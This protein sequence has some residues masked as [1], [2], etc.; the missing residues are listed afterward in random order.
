[1]LIFGNSKTDVATQ[2]MN[3]REFALGS[4]IAFRNREYQ[5]D[6]FRDRTLIAHELTRVIQQNYGRVMLGAS[7]R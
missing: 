2:S 1:M 3:A 5:P 7:H 4:S 6:T